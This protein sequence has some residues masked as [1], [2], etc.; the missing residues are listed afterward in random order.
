MNYEYITVAAHPEI[1]ANQHPNYYSPMF[2]MWQ[3]DDWEIVSVTVLPP[4]SSCDM[5]RAIGVLRRSAEHPRAPQS[6]QE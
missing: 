3:A 1:T 2:T 6:G 5:C 4:V